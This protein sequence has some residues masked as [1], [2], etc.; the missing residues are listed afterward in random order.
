MFGRL[1]FRFAVAVAFAY[2]LFILWMAAGLGW[3]VL[4]AVSVHL[5]LRL[6]QG[7]DRPLEDWPVL[8]WLPR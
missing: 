4:F 7:G 1:V 3:V 5:G 2:A 6:A 8:R